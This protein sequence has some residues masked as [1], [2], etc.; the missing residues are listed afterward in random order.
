[1]SQEGSFRDSTEMLRELL[2]RHH[3]LEALRRARK[4][5]L[6]LSEDA[7]Q[8]LLRRL[9]WP[10]APGEVRTGLLLTQLQYVAGYGRLDLLTLATFLLAHVLLPDE[11]DEGALA[12]TALRLDALR[13]L[14]DLHADEVER[15]RARP[16]MAAGFDHAGNLDRHGLSALTFED[17]VRQHLKDAE[18][19]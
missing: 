3:R 18:D 5:P 17:V 10:H 7:R 6:P 11:G 14:L 8:D 1:M 2:Q 4:P 13:D 12:W 15:R 9:Q 16:T 19:E